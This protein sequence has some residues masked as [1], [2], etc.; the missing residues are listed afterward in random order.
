MNYLVYLHSL[1]F[2]HKQL[3]KIFKDNRD[4][5]YFF[6]SLSFEL[7]S[8][9]SFKE[10][11]ILKVLENKKVLN[12]KKIDEIIKKLDIKIITFYDE[13]YINDL[14]NI[15]NPPFL[16][17]L[18]WEINKNDNFFSVV[19]SRKISQYTKKT[20]NII[21]PKLTKYFTIVSGW[22]WWCDTIAHK[23][24]L[25][26]NF[27]TIVV[28]WTWIDITYPSSNKKL[29]DDILKSWWWLIS[30]FPLET[31]GSI[32]T[33]PIRN[34]IVAWIWKWLLVLEAWEKSWTLITAKL[35]LDQW[36]DVFAIPWDILSSNYIWSNN[37]IKNSEAKLISSSDDILNDYWYNI[38]ETI[39]KEISFWNM[40][41]KEIYE[42]LKYNLSLSVDDFLQKTNFSYWELG[43]NLSLMEINQIIK[44][45]LFWKY[46]LV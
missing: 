24:A 29:F 23:I 8:S 22:A 19:W 46:E 27:K 33:F 40:I 4:Y 18:R 10:S 20:A 6:E 13:S 3:H 5:K 44:K 11:F 37:L 32:Y 16:I 12:T 38:W 31:K 45:N 41:Q 43:L 26:N 1:W 30:I 2:S 14:K 15:S 21:I 35:A 34:E 36:K 25:E 17:Y 42:L 39:K 9:F 28:F 7:L